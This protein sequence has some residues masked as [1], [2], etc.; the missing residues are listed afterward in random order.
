M[1]KNA[2]TFRKDFDGKNTTARIVKPRKNLEKFFLSIFY[3]FFSDL[4]RKKES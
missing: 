3:Q 1:S 4:Q 2:E